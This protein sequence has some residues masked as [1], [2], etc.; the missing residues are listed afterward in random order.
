M[1][2]GTT[3]YEYTAKGEVRKE[4]K[5]I[6]SIQY[7]TQYSYDQNGNLKTMTYP[8]GRVITYNYSND[9]ATSVLN[10][11]ATLASSINY[12]PFGG[13]SSITY[14]T[15]LTGSI[16]YDNQYRVSGIAVGSVMNRRMQM[17]TGISPGSRT[18]SMR[19]R[20][21]HLPTML[22][23]VSLQLQPPEYGAVL[24]GRMMELAT[25]RR[26][27]SIVYSYAP[28]TNKLAGAGGT[29][30]GYDSNG[31]TTSQA[32]RAY[33]YN[34]NQR[35]IL[36]VDGAMTA[37]YTYNGNGQRVKKVVNGITTI[38]HYNRDGLLVAESDGIGATTAEYV[39]LSSL[40]LAKIEGMN[41]YFYANDHLATPQKM[42]DSTGTVVSLTTNLSGSDCHDIDSHEQSP[43]S[44]VLRCRDR[45]ELRIIIGTIIL[46]LEIY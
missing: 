46:S 25:D 7:V 42:T 5:T 15:G 3:V 4:T 17:T 39:Y 33:T 11:A 14:G 1:R 24:P 36:V 20:I 22:L 40:P 32:A 43:L 16:S 13:L 6:D 34:Q 37:G 10:N 35:L 8:S 2:G 29:S 31:N 38:F 44:P 27:G 26:E 21:S 19:L 23:I 12:K 18:S 30:F 28:S 41:T 9:R 45:I